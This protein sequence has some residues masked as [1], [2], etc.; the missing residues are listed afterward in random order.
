MARKD[1]SECYNFYDNR[2]G[3]SINDVTIILIL[4]D[5]IDQNADSFHSFYEKYSWKIQPHVILKQLPNPKSI[6]LI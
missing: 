3:L 2:E 6:E 1:S 5:C 4:L